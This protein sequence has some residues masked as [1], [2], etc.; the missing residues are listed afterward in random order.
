MTGDRFLGQIDEVLNRFGVISKGLLAFQ[1]QQAELK[2]KNIKD[3]VMTSAAVPPAHRRDH[4]IF[5]AQH[6]GRKDARLSRTIG[7]IPGYC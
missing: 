2:G 6:R 7:A 1:A 5:W 4:A 3:K